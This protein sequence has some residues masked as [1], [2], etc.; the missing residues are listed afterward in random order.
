MPGSNL[1]SRRPYI[2]RLLEELK[3]GASHCGLLES[4]FVGGG[5]PSLL[6][7]AEWQEIGEAIHTFFKQSPGC[8]WTMEA[9]PESLTPGLVEIWRALG[10][11]R[12]SL[13]I[14]AF[15]P[16]LRATIG[17]RGNL[18]RLEEVVA[19]LRQNGIRRL[20]FDLIFNIPG[21]TLSQW[22]DTLMQALSYAP[23]HIS[24]YALTLEEGTRLAK[25][26]PPLKDEDFLAFWN[27]TD[28]GLAT[29]GIHRYEISNF[30]LPGEQCRHNHAIW[31]GGTYLGCG[32]AAASFDGSLRWTNPSSLD[33][34]LAHQPPEKDLLPPEERAAEIL[35]LGFRTLAGWK[36]SEFT[37]TTG[38]DALALRG[39]ALKKLETMGLVH[40]TSHGAAP[41]PQGLLFNDNLAMELI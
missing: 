40:L 41:T 5:T 24:A 1:E 30:S 32:P 26:L 10:V 23:T 2:A 12:I 7:I 35:A 31:H 15:Q 9:N 38:F 3:T 14:Q 13:G 29:A 34:W 37:A 39:N 16:E 6:S 36:W 22:H 4:I 33:H 11:N 25:V 27:E 18:D 19:A 28:R 17:R 8:E 21:Q 20:N